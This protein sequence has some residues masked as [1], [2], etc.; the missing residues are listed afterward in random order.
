[1]YS[2][3]SLSF[4]VGLYLSGT[5]YVK[6]L[7]GDLV[8]I[9]VP[10]GLAHVPKDVHDLHGPPLVLIPVCSVELLEWRSD[11]FLPALLTLS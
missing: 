9:F 3:Q 4:S 11:Q 2:A 5:L 1:M 10:S 7:N 8:S 6:P